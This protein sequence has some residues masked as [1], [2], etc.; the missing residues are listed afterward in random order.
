MG[1]RYCPDGIWKI[2]KHP[3]TD[4]VFDGKS[5]PNWEYVK[6]KIMD[7][8][9]HI[10]S[11]DYLGLDVIITEDGMKLCE[12][13]SH[14]AMDYEQIMCGPALKKEKVNAF[15]KYKGLDNYDAE[16]LYAAYLESQE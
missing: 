13:N 11:L 6:N 2:K 10:S 14:P 9:D 15:F 3:D 12:I 16:K 1:K 4:Y 8:C 7:I 5:L